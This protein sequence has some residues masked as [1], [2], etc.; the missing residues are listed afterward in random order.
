MIHSDRFLELLEKAKVI[1][2]ENSSLFF[3]YELQCRERDFLLSF[4]ELSDIEELFK[5]E[6][7]ADITKRTYHLFENL[8]FLN[9]DINEIK[10]KLQ[11][12]Y[13]THWKNRSDFEIKRDKL[14]GDF[15]DYHNLYLQIQDYT[16]LAYVNRE[17]KWYKSYVEE[18]IIT[19]FEYIFYS[20]LEANSFQSLVIFEDV[21]NDQKINNIPSL[22]RERAKIY[23]ENRIQFEK[24]RDLFADIQYSSYLDCMYV[25]M[26]NALQRHQFF[27]LNVLQKVFERHIRYNIRRN[28]LQKGNDINYPKLSYELRV[29]HAKSMNH[30][31]IRD[32]ARKIFNNRREFRIK[33]DLYLLFSVRT[34]LEIAEQAILSYDHDHNNREEFFFQPT[35]YNPFKNHTK[36]CNVGFDGYSVMESVKYFV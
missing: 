23:F 8:N 19:H 22:L 33:K 10:D 9:T 26:S 36:K 15:C 4:E 16:D 29:G 7:I 14:L 18:E 30:I 34:Y 25:A 2:E 21:N 11:E 28:L 17:R 20:E 12:S 32:Y 5:K 13:E 31:L 35:E 24:A 6:F 27:G 1:R 3:L